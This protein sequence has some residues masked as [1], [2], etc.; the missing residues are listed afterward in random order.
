MGKRQTNT[1]S[2][3]ATSREL[4][5]EER[6][7][8]NFTK[9]EMTPV[10]VD[11]SSATPPGEALVQWRV[12]SLA[13]MEKIMSTVNETCKLDHRELTDTELDA[14]TGGLVVVTPQNVTL[15]GPALLVP[16]A[17]PTTNG[18]RGTGGQIG[19]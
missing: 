2:T 5:E 19:P 11:T 9:I 8:L 6:G 15:L 12:M 10:S 17:P 1:I 16:A 7:S 18:H 13:W 14:V 3:S 4:S